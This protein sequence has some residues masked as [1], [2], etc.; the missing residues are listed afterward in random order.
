MLRKCLLLQD[1]S[2]FKVMWNT[3]SHKAATWFAMAHKRISCYECF[4]VA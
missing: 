1:I 4:F 3:V 2:E